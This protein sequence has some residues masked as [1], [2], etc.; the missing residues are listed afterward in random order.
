[1]RSP[2]VSVILPVYN[3]EQYIA[4]SIE[5]ILGQSYADFEFIILNDGSTDASETIIKKYARIDSRVL[6][7]SYRENSG[8]VPRLNFGIKQARGEFIARMDHDDIADRLRL[9]IQ[10]RFLQDNE[11]YVMCGSWYNNFGELQGPAQLPVDDE[12]IRVHLMK[13]NPFCHPSVLIR[14]S[15]IKTNK[16]FYTPELMPSEDYK[17]WVDL[18]KLGKVANI[19]QYLLNYRTHKCNTSK[20][21]TQ[22]QILLRNKVQLYYIKSFLKKV[23]FREE[24]FQIIGP[25]LAGRLERDIHNIR[26]VYHVIRKLFLCTKLNGKVYQ[27]FLSSFFDLCTTSSHLGLRVFY[28]Y[29]LVRGEKVDLKLRV[30]LFLKCLFRY[31]SL[32]GE[33]LLGGEAT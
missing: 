17:L 33:A 2:T 8:Y 18:I 9:D 20:S 5:S 11:G 27:M 21:R 24:E 16:L 15:V 25:F 31:R 22:N 6:L 13:G 12:D 19:P 1:M 14:A 29:F 4:N 10:V 32:K 26:A 28:F 7:Y 30:R 3:G 23:A